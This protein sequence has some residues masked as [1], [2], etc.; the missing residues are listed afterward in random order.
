M[1]GLFVGAWRATAVAC[2]L[3]AATVPIAIAGAASYVAVP[4]GW[5]RS[6]LPN[7]ATR[8]QRQ[9]A[10]GGT[11]ATAASITDA[12]DRTLSPVAAFAVR[13]TPVSNEEFLRFVHTNPQW[14][15][16]RVPPLFAERSYLAH[17][18]APDALGE[19]ALPEQPVTA[20]SWFAAQAF[21]ESENARLPTWLEWEYLAAADATRRDA[22]DDPAWRARILAWYGQPST[23]ALPA[24]GGAANLYGV[25]DLDDLVWE[26]VDDFN[27]L[28]ISADSR[29]QGDPDV[30]RFCGSAA[31]ALADRDNYAV[32]MRIALLSSLKA[33]DT[34]G[35]LG[36][37]CA[38][39]TSGD[40]Q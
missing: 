26:W 34:T 39:A 27:A 15:R 9:P 36:F 31:L 16:D 10:A 2:I 1:C 4:G 28:M 22:R 24:V 7:D 5:L 17:W 18:S 14:R 20:V 29:D 23:S 38:R 3:L 6:V 40:S 37:R 13:V 12:T 19:S 35:N 33:A 11:A 30:L 21:C 25:R 32:L 8:V